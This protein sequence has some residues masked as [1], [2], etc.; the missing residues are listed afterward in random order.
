MF[1]KIIRN[2]SGSKAQRHKAYLLCRSVPT[3][4]VTIIHWSWLFKNKG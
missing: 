1:E 4:V 3:W 2:Y